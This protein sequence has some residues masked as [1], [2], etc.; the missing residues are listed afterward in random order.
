MTT[1]VQPLRFPSLPDRKV[2][3]WHPFWVIL[4]FVSIFFGVVGLLFFLDTYCFPN[5]T[6]SVPR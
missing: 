2:K 1:R 4:L 6:S 3:N 5:V